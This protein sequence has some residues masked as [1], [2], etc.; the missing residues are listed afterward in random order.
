MSE[1]FWTTIPFTEIPLV[2]VAALVGLWLLLRNRAT[3]A[4][5]DAGFD[6][7]IGAGQP[8]VMEFFSNT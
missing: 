3:E 8:V 4:A 5:G 1:I 7:M 2:V 6:S